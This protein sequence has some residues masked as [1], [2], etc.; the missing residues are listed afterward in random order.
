MCWKDVEINR[1]S[2][3]KDNRIFKEV[4]LDLAY[5]FSKIG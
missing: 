1:Q 4:R 5:V 2:C 3:K